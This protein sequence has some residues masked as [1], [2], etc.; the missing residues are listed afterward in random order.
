[1]HKHHDLPSRAPDHDDTLHK[2]SAR[3]KTATGAAKPA[4]QAP[5]APPAPAGD[6][7]K[8]AVESTTGAH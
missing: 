5:A 4:E 7:D 6:Q 1:M 3:T 2:I 8:G